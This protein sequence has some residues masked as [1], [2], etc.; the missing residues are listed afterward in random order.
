[1]MLL[2]HRSSPLPDRR[3]RLYE[4]CLRSLLSARV[5]RAERQGA[6]LQPNQWRPDD[7]QERWRAA[8]QLAYGLLAEGARK[9]AEW[10]FVATAENAPAST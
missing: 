9:R 3:H 8:E 1:M 5:D 2:V 10:Q 4:T 6:Q 7:M